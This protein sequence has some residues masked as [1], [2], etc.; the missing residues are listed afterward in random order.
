MG[1]EQ[2]WIL[3]KGDAVEFINF[4]DSQKDIKRL[5]SNLIHINY[6]KINMIFQLENQ[7]SKDAY[8]NW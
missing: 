7:H 6:F 5:S 1:Y 4:I 8:L 3:Y 2:N